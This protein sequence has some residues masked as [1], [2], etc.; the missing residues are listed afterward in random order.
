[1]FKKKRGI[2]FHEGKKLN[3][4]AFFKGERRNDS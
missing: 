4:F 1:M 2:I 3:Q